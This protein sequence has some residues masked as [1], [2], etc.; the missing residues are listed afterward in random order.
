MESE[1]V[2][3]ESMHLATGMY[4][5]E[6]GSLTM[7]KCTS[8]GDRIRVKGAS[9]VMEDSRVFG[10]SGHGMQ[11]EGEGDVK[12]TRCTV[13]DNGSVGILI[14]GEHASA[15]LVDCVIRKNGSCGVLANLGMIMLRGG[16]I[17]ENVSYGVHALNSGTVTVAKAEEGKPQTVS[18]D[19]GNCR[20]WSTLEDG[21]I[22]GIPQEKIVTT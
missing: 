16:T 6:G 4:I 3:F 17:S 21:E 2:C 11:C 20:D 15:E 22:I 9:L 5:C 12:L 1:G 13:E 7:T 19:N 8:T 10:C 14:Y 18:K